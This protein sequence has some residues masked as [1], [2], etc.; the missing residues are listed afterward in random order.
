[1]IKPISVFTEKDHG[2]T[3]HWRDNLIHPIRAYWGDG[4][5]DWEKWKLDFEF[6]K[7]YFV[8]SN[9]LQNSDVAFL[10]F[11]LNYYAK[12][13]KIELFKNFLN[14]MHEFDKKVFVWVEGDYDVTIDYPNCIFIKY[15]GYK[16]KINSNMI[17]QP[18]D[19]K[20]DL[21]KKYCN[22]E[23]KIRE[24]ND[25]PSIGF[26]GVAD[27]SKIKLV[28]LIIKQSLK[29]FKHTFQNAIFEP[30]PIIPYLVGR[31]TSLETIKKLRGITSDIILRKSFA[32][33]IRNNDMNAR[34]AFI[35]NIINNDYT[36]CMRGGGNYSLR[37]YETLCLGR[38]P[39]F[40]NTDCILPFENIIDWEGLCLWVEEGDINKIGQIVLDFHS[41][42]S[43]DEFIERQIKCREIWEKFLSKEGF[44]KELNMLITQNMMD[45]KR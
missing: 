8:L 34:L 28:L 40:I 6:Y 42:M 2:E 13:N 39:L 21:L 31:K 25:N 44:A 10:P 17:I 15:A 41:S 11:T 23:L 14:K 45:E 33:G 43:N 12:Y 26:D 32:E 3:E 29:Y 27:Y 19:L 37:L 20:D 16:S 35:N 30:G 36:F 22:G 9:E 38:I 1:M 18:G 7:K 5:A 4:T 24:K